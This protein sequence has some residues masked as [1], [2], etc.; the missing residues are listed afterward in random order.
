MA[1]VPGPGVFFFVTISSSVGRRENIFP[2]TFENVLEWILY[3]S[4]LGTNFL[5]L[6]NDKKDPKCTLSLPLANEIAFLGVLKSA[7]G[8]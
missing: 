1:A 5:L 7:G 8:L 2:L 3:L 4:G 6:V